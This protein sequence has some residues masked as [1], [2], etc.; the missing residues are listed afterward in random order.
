MQ[1]QKLYSGTLLEAPAGMEEQVHPKHCFRF[2]ETFQDMI[3][4]WDHILT[5]AWA[6]L[7][8]KLCIPE[9]EWFREMGDF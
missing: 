9:E 6:K 1:S 3:S 7:F 2:F 8:I 4:S 5:T